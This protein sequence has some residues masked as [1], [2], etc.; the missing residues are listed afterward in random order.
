M[1][2]DDA[3]LLRTEAFRAGHCVFD[4]VYMFPETGL[5][6]EARAA[7]ARAANGLEMLLYQG[8]LAFSFWTGRDAPVEAMRV[9]LEESVYGR[10]A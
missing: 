9:V 7:G 8:A 3:P 1:R 5:M 2:E 10:R 4:L 6:R